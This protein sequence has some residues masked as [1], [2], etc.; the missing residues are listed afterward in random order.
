MAVDVD[1]IISTRDVFPLCTIIKQLQRDF[2]QLFTISQVVTVQ[3]ND[4]QPGHQHANMFKVQNVVAK[5]FL[6]VSHD[7]YYYQ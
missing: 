5:T 4:V 7:L 6:S 2:F 1:V 3:C